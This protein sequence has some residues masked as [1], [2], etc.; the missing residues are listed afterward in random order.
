M[1][2]YFEWLEIECNSVFSPTVAYN[3]LIYNVVI[4]Y[5]KALS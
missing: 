1:L 4:L 3:T 2:S 5:D